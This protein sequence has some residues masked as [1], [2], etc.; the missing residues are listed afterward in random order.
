MTH[1]STRGLARAARPRCIAP[2]LSHST[3]AVILRDADLQPHRSRYWKT[4]TPDDA[5]RHQAARKSAEKMSIRLSSNLITYFLP[6]PKEVVYGAW[7]LFDDYR[8]TY[9]ALLKASGQSS[10]NI[11]PVR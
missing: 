7:G 6:G 5:F 4:P 9:Y 1:W 2:A 3:V 10:G 8:I 11:T